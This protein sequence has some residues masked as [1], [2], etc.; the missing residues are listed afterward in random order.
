MLGL[1]L[2]HKIKLAVL[3]KEQVTRFLSEATHD[4]GTRHAGMTGN[5]YAF[6]RQIERPGGGRPALI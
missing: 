2:T 4:C 3:R 6:S 5:E 1:I